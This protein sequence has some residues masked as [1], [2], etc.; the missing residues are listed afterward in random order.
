MIPKWTNN[1]AKNGPGAVPEPTDSPDEPKAPQKVAERA[2][3]QPRRAKGTQ[4]DDTSTPKE[5]TKAPKGCQKRPQ[6]LPKQ[7]KNDGKTQ[8]REASE[9]LVCKNRKSEFYLHGSTVLVEK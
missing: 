1:E 7:T 5:T 9:N 2:H 6:G 4:K 8:K 3:R